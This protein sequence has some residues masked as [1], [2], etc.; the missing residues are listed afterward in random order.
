MQMHKAKQGN[1]LAEESVAQPF[2]LQKAD[3]ALT[4]NMMLEGHGNS[5]ISFMNNNI[6][7]KVL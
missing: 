2:S 1:A 5:T 4:L 6:D 7:P 3:S